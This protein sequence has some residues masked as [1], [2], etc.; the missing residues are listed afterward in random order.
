MT[1]TTKLTRRELETHFAEKREILFHGETYGIMDWGNGT[2]DILKA[3]DNENGYVQ[4]NQASETFDCHTKA[5]EYLI[6]FILNTQGNND[7]SKTTA[8]AKKKEPEEPIYEG[9]RTIR[10]F[11]REIYI[12]DDHTMKQEQIRQKLV[13][14]YGFPHFDKNKVF[15]DFDSTSG[16]LEVMMKM[17]TKG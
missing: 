12:E 8:K 1:T 15:Y 17:Q 3:A 2:F 5:I 13:S 7:K 6:D 9:P 11:G 14:E 16:T 4:I 10:V